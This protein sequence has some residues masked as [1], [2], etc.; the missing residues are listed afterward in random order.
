M[1]KNSN[2]REKRR[3]YILVREKPFKNFIPYEKNNEPKRDPTILT[4]K[5]A[6]EMLPKIVKKFGL[7]NVV[8]SKVF[9]FD[10]V[11]EETIFYRN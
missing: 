1:R 7:G 11:A 5:E 6:L 2:I 3:Y 10:V 4:L 9:F 8:L